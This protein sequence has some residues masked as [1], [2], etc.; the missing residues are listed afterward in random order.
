[1]A[2]EFGKLWCLNP[3][4]RCEK[5]LRMGWVFS[6]TE[7]LCSAQIPPEPTPSMSYKRKEY[8]EQTTRPLLQELQEH[9]NEIP[10][11]L[12]PSEVNTHLQ[13]ETSTAYI[14]LNTGSPWICSV[15]FLTLVYAL[16]G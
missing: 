13:M 9:M 14:V 10:S 12:G 16:G 6:V 7:H 11:V 15:L 2:M 3:E 4:E 5:L 1:M 8:S